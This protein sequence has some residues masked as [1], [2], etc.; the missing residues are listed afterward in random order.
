[1]AP[2]FLRLVGA[3]GERKV[4]TQKRKTKMSFCWSTL[5][6]SSVIFFLVS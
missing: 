3:W 6:R 1:M 5:L 4:G 2:A